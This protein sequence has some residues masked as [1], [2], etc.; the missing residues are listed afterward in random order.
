MNNLY[1]RCFVIAGSVELWVSLK[2][3]TTSDDYD[4]FLRYC[5][6]GS[7]G[8]LFTP[9]LYTNQWRV[10]LSEAGLR[11]RM[12][13][14]NWTCDCT[15]VGIFA[16]KMNLI[17]ELTIWIGII[18]KCM[19]SFEFW[20]F[21]E[22]ICLVKDGWPVLIRSRVKCKSNYE[23]VSN[24]FHFGITPLLLFWKLLEGYCRIV[25]LVL[26]RGQCFKANL[27]LYAWIALLCFA[28]ESSNFFRM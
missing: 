18:Q 8:E 16:N 24:G 6:L 20:C 28:V 7:V 3:V 15:Y 12:I 13:A 21:R 26:A 4:P 19:S 11:S 1:S 25:W 17:F 5:L 2:L 14:K 10:G 23:D 27:L 22:V 9:K